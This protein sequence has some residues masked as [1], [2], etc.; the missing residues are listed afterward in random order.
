[1]RDVRAKPCPRCQRP[2]GVSWDFALSRRDNVT[3]ICSSCGGLEAHEQG[4]GWL[5]EPEALRWWSDRWFQPGRGPV[6]TEA[7][8]RYSYGRIDIPSGAVRGSG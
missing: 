8:V 4:R 5:M 6:N 1:M 7:G 2:P 3:I